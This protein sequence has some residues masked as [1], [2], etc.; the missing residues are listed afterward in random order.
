M[1]QNKLL[2]IQ[3][4]I[5]IIKKKIELPYDPAISLLGTYLERNKRYLHPNVCCSTIHNSQDM[6]GT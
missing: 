3:E 4:S 5:E 1:S 2:R 6:E